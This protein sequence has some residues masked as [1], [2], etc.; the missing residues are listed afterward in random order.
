MSGG[1]TTRRRLSALAVSLSIA[2]GC[3]G[4]ET[5]PTPDSEPE[6]T[7]TTLARTSDGTLRLG[8]LVPRS[9]PGASLGEPLVEIARAAVDEINAAG[10]VNG[11]PIDLVIRD[12][13]DDDATALAAVSAFIDV[14]GVDAVVGPLSSRVALSVLPTLIDAGV[15]VCSPAATTASLADLPDNGLFV[16]TSPTDTLAALAMAQVAARTGES[17]IA[18]AY[19]DDPYGRD[20]AADVRRSLELEGLRATTEVGYDPGDDDYTSEVATVVDSL[21][22]VLVLLS[23]GEGGSRFLSTLATSVAGVTVIVNDAFASVDFSGDP[24]RDALADIEIIG[25]A[26]DTFVGS[27]VEAPG[28][29]EPVVVT[30]IGTTADPTGGSRATSPPLATATIDCIALLAV[31]V[32]SVASDDPGVFMP[33]VI[34]ASK[35]G[36]G[37]ADFAGCRD[38]LESGLNVDYNGPSSVLALDPNGDPLLAVFVTFGIDDSGRAAYRD[39][40][41][42]VSAP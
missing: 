19:P 24:S 16:R 5:G 10:G 3:S 38:L 20:L 8:L 4:A 31:A 30:T 29:E 36:S 32:E 1:R 23:G 33:L 34:P 27:S 11:S 41:G 2:A 13:G 26:V 25:V 9:G 15:G 6:R 22:D 12:E 35:G 18:V 42:V 40:I 28:S 7:T 39:T 21:P 37:C 14:D 17:E